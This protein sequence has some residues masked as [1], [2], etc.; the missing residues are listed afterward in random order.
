[1]NF[2][3]FFETIGVPA[4]GTKVC[5]PVNCG[6]GLA[7]E[8]GIN[9][10][11]DDSY[12]VVL[13]DVTPKMFRDFLA[14]LASSGR[15]ET[16]HREVNGNIFSEFAFGGRIIYTY[17]TREAEQARVIID[18]A[19]CPVSEMDDN[20]PH[21]HGDT[22]LMQFSLKYGKM[23][24]SH[25]CDCGM[26]YVMR[27]RDNS[28]IIID[29]G[30]LEQATED[31][32]DEFMRRLEDLTNT[33]KGGKIR[34]AAW[35]CTHNHDDH[36]D[37]FIKLLKREKDVLCIERV[38]FNFPSKTLMNYESPCTDKLRERLKK[39]APNAKYLKM[40]TGQSVRFPD[41]RL[42]VLTTHEDILPRSY[43]AK[44][45]DT[46]RGM[47][48][49]TTVFQITFDDASVIFLGDAEE[50][51]GEA[52]ITLYGKNLLSCKYLQCAH[53][54][55]NDDRNI[56]G[57]IRAEKLLVPQCRFISMTTE[58]DNM[59]Y[60]TSLFGSENM[61]YAGDCTY[62]FTIKDGNES[63]S[64]FEPKGYVYDNSGY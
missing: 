49:S 40:H 16:F 37:V 8:D 57:N 41:A 53:H 3:E 12:M 22:A 5:E 24:R 52:L 54:M 43:R 10:G 46:Y 9:G 25:S 18:N 45:G 29:G 6:A 55:I 2:S 13:G 63:I 30:E 4:F 39:Y 36:M 14:S 60:L 17:F 21:V 28:V 15:K 26:L 50:T 7:I 1:M 19:S 48:E 11:A 34:V 47:N 31:A 27:L 59:R 56:Y 51:N 20:E 64:Y 62:V 33:E 35:I 42:D 23:I 61:Y 58:C 44:D 32:C 38:M